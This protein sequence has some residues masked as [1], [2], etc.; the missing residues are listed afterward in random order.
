MDP[1]AYR[2]HKHRPELEELLERIV[3]ESA[4]IADSYNTR[5]ERQSQIILGTSSMRQALQDVLKEY[6]QNV[7]ALLKYF[8]IIYNFY[9]MLFL[10]LNKKRQLRIFL[11]CL[12]LIK[13]LSFIKI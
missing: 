6:E 12:F 11:S 9:F 2:P 8:Y 1:A 10:C 7:T 13:Y 5:P 3:S 4:K